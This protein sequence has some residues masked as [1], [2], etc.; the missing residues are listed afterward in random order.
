MAIGAYASSILTRDFGVPFYPALLAGGLLAGGTGV[1]VGF[2]AIRIKGIYLLLLTLAFGEMIRVFF[3]NFTPTGAASGMGGMELETN[4]ANVYVSVGLL[5]LFFFRLRGSRMGRAFESMREDEVAAEAIGINIVRAKLIAFGIGAFVAGIGGALY[6]HYA[7]Y[8]ESSHFG[9]L[10]AVEFFVFV[11]F[12]GLEVFW[13]AVVGAVLLTIIP[14]AV[15]FLKDF[16]MVFFGGVIVIF[17]IVRPQGLIDRQ[18]V[19]DIARHVK[20][21]LS[22][23]GGSR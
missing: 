7:L 14:E 15:R 11:V 23:V 13:G 6:A 1:L 8:L 5:M 17:M 22:M 9:F 18:L 21:S 12:G 20:R 2:P 4:L 16:R 19:D 10:L 3:L